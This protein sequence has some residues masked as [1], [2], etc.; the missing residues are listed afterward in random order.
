MAE[1]N[2]PSR[3]P[4][5]WAPRR[6]PALGQVL[7]LAL[8]GAMAVVGTYRWSYG[9]ALEDLRQGT[10]R[11]LEFLSSDLASALDKFDTLPIVLST[12]PEIV[13]LLN[14][15]DDKPRRD[16]V[17]RRLARLAQ[18]SKVAAIYLMDRHGT[19]IAASN[20]ATP[21]SF[22]G[23]N[24][25][26]RPYFRDAIAGGIGRFYAI[27]ATTGEPGYFLAHPVRDDA[28][29]A[30]APAP[31]VIAVKISLADIEANWA[32]SGEPLMLADVHGVVFL[33]SR[34]EWKFRTLETLDAPTRTRIRAAQQYGDNT[35][36]PLPLGATTPR[37]RR[38][39]GRMDWTLLAMA[40]VDE[41]ARLAR[42][43]AAAVGFACA[44]ML[45]AALYARLRR[46]RDEERRLARRE[47]ERASAELE[48]RVAQ[49]TA[50]L[51]DANRELAAKIAELRRTQAVLRATQD[52]LIQ[53][54]KLAVLGQMAAGITHELNQPLT[55]LRALVRQRRACCSTLDAAATRSRDNLQHDH[56][57]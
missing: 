6:W 9:N 57:S 43:H 31:G 47:L 3:A 26:F 8:A 36:D 48:L 19:T 42:G 56:A 5:R 55:A 45:V 50:V 37:E 38:P 39:V 16:A 10:Q 30:K 2:I 13:E 35:L 54:G 27:G 15:A 18:E 20:A 32:R 53:A 24:Y 11:R 34:P 41:V 40:E 46:R 29:P 33:A 44:F 14:H 51:L 1:L 28:A 7:L 12:H 25:A 21:Q 22:V 52:E 17:N 4:A 23:Q 49:R